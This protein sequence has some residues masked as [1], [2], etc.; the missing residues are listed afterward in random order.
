MVLGSSAATRACN[1]GILESCHTLGVMWTKGQG[2]S[3]D[4]EEARGLLS[5]ACN[6]KHKLSC[7]ELNT[8]D[9]RATSR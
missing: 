2:G 6:G 7:E 9:A 8:L 3:A 5:E 1:E 4:L